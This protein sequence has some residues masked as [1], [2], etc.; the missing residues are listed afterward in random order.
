MRGAWKLDG[1]Y[2]DKR[3]KTWKDFPSLHAWFWYS[4]RRQA[5]FD[6]NGDWRE[7]DDVV[8][9]AVAGYLA[10][11][12]ISVEDLRAFADW[13]T[14]QRGGWP[15]WNVVQ[16]RLEQ[17]TDPEEYAARKARIRASADARRERLLASRV[18]RDSGVPGQLTR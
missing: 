2:P 14:Q 17:L 11:V 9:R 13:L 12:A 7:V 3:W 6:G 1:Y 4:A 10:D 16:D 8:S 5:F 18:Q 15:A